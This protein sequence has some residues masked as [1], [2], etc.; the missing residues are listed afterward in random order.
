[1]EADVNSR[2]VVAHKSQRKYVDTSPYSAI[3]QST[4]CHITDTKRIFHIIDMKDGH[5]AQENELI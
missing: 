4:R 2:S 1:M 5:S 3:N